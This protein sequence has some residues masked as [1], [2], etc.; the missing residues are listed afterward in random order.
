MRRS[1]KSTIVSAT[2]HLKVPALLVLGGLKTSFQVLEISLRIFLDSAAPAAQGAG[3]NV[4]LICVMTCRSIFWMRPS[5]LKPRLMS[6]R[7][8][9]AL[10]AVDPGVSPATNRKHADTAREPVRSPGRKD[11]S[12]SEPRV[13]TAVGWG[14]SSRIRAH[15]AEAADRYRSANGWR[16]KFLE[17]WIPA[18]DCV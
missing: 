17:A 9:P 5:V 11:F 16:L 3:H 10:T 6:I 15:Y 2:R 18:H 14:R 13:P 1:V 7:L 8:K 4:D 12:P